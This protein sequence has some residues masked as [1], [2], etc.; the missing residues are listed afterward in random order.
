[1][2]ETLSNFNVTIVG[3]SGKSLET[4]LL[5]AEALRDLCPT[6][7]ALGNHFTLQTHTETSLSGG[8][9]GK[10]TV[11]MERISYTRRLYLTDS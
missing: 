11:I 7:A 8:Q 3:F 10:A 5:S 9:G 4:S 6:S 1:M 2:Q